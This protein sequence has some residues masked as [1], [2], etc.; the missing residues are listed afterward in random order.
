MRETMKQPDVD[1][2]RA[3]HGHAVFECEH[4]ANG[5]PCPDDCESERLSDCCGALPMRLD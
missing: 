2:C 1:I 4:E 3:C 5:E